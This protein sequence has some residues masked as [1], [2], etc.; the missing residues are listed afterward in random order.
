MKESI[1]DPDIRQQL[2]FVF[3]LSKV[4]EA[5]DALD[6]VPAYDNIVTLNQQLRR[7]RR[8]HQQFL[9]MDFCTHLEKPA[10]NPD[11]SERYSKLCQREEKYGYI[12][13]KRSD[14]SPDVY[15]VSEWSD[16]ETAEKI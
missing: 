9:L 12:E 11:T 16:T 13:I 10:G 3:L 4:Y 2:N 7:D 1:P 6:F 5:W 8:T 14:I 15:N